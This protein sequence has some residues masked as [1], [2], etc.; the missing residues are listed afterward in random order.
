MEPTHADLVVLVAV[1]YAIQVAA[2]FGIGWLVWR[3]ARESKASLTESQRLTR[4]VAALVVQETE[5]IRNLLDD[6]GAQPSR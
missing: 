5:K 2:L 3:G 6:S 4:A 1:S